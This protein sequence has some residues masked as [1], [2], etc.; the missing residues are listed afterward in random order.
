MKYALI[1]YRDSEN[2]DYVYFWTELQGE[3]WVHV[4]PMFETEDGAHTW[5]DGIMEETKN[6]WLHL[7]R[8]LV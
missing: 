4:S 2:N 1:K 3:T 7:P 8:N 5:L 6:V